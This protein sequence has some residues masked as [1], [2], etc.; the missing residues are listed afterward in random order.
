MYLKQIILILCMAKQ[1]RIML[2]DFSR[3]DFPRVV[4]AMPPVLGNI[5]LAFYDD[6][7]AT[8]AW[9]DTGRTRWPARAVADAGRRLLVKSGRLRRSLRMSHAGYRITISTD[10]PYAQVHNEGGTIAG[11]AN[12]RTHS[13]KVGS[14]RVVVK[15]HTRSVNFTMP[16]RQFMDKP[17]SPI[18]SLL[19]RRLEKHLDLA[20]AQAMR[21][22]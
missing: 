9:I 8:S 10:V 5:A 4:R 3:A 1:R 19:R 20:F 11:T 22:I 14:R 18:S 2:P 16:Q 7:F 21:R 15:A 17:G 6:R 12:V 13:R